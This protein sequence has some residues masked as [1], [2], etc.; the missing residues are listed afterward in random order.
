MITK[1]LKASSASA[2]E[3]DKFAAM[4]GFAKRAGKIVIG[5]D[6][7]RTAKRIKILSVDSAASKS[8]TE[9]MENLA[10]RLGVPLVYAEGLE[11]LVGDRC[12]AVGVTDANM[13][14]EMEKFVGS[15]APQYHF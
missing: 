6:A 7:L 2:M 14:R 13:A 9:N 8:L 12:M 10:H 11:T 3:S 15:G 4:L 5:Y 1:D